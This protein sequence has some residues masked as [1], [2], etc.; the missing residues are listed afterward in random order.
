MQ[1]LTI[2][3]ITSTNTKRD[4]TPLSGKFGPYY[5][6]RADTEEQGTVTWFSKTAHTHKPGDKINGTLEV[7]TSEKDGKTYTN[8]NF[9]FPKKG[10]GVDPEEFRKLTNRMTTMELSIDRKFA[11][12]KSEL[13]LELKGK[14]QT[15]ADFAKYQEPHPM[16]GNPEKTYQGTINANVNDPVGDGIPLDAY[17]DDEIP[18]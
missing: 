16:L 17:K 3:T 5:I 9:S 18:F 10:D 11:E 14:V 1:E 4:G 2:K 13:M 6:V 15:T 12:M 8:K 7:T